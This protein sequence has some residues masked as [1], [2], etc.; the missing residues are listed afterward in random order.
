MFLTLLSHQWL[1]T[2]RSSVF[3]KNRAVN[4]IL[5]VLIA[6]FGLNF[7]VLGF[8]VDN[9]LLEMYPGQHPVWVFNGFMFFYFLVDLFMRFMLQELPI[10][11][12]QP[13]LHLPLPKGKLIHFVLLKSIPSI[14]NFFLLLV[15]VP[16]LFDA[17]IP[18]YGT[19]VGV[20]WLIS[21]LLL[22]FFNNFL[23]IYFK[24]QLST[25]PVMTL[26]FGLA[27]VGLILLDYLHVFSLR[28]AS[29]IAFDYLLEQPWLV[30]LPAL[31]VLF[32]YF[33]N[34]KF[35]KAHT[36]PEEIAV[37]KETKAS[38]GDIA[39]LQRFGD[40]GK[41]IALEM[42]LIWRHKR[43]KSIITISALFIFYG[44]IF[45]N[46]PVFLDGFAMLIFVG[47]F[48]TGMFMFNYGQFIP[49]WQ[50]AHFDALLSRRISP[51]QFYQAK[52]WFFVPVTF[53]AF[54]LTLPYAF[55]SYKIILINFAAFLFN[56]GINAFVVFYFSVLNRN[57]LN[58]SGSAFS[59]QG[60]G[61]SKFVMQLPLMLLPLIVYAPFGFL[62]IPYWGVF[63]I[64]IIGLAGFVFHRQLLRLTTQRFVEHKYKI[65]A[66]FRQS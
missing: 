11:S 66:G 40:V 49:S 51:Y 34:Y 26:Y 19:G 57:R 48:T 42:K 9:L 41:L 8:F 14:F 3:Q 52:F 10:L 59:W 43:S 7:L 33:L 56:I 32:A 24:R 45:Y 39:F 2:R 23:L 12:I 58:L 4:I 35:L 62:D 17:V 36:Y 64:G 53:V 30:V 60:V 65:A 16:F 15:F 22:T 25:K 37:K 21:L 46:N 29:S 13:Y 38:G 55:I 50:S 27:V 5:G 6:Y 61:A 54:L 28:E 20:I 18:A 31:L 63:A 1:E 44:L 47:I